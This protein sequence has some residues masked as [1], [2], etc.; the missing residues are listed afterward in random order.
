LDS[1]LDGPIGELLFAEGVTGPACLDAGFLDGVALQELVELSLF[2]PTFVVVVEL[3]APR[4]GVD[5]GGVV[6]TGPEKSVAVPV[7]GSGRPSLRQ[8]AIN[9]AE[10]LTCVLIATIW[11][12]NFS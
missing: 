5:D 1:K 6:P 8:A 7:V 2:A 12:M 4:A 9:A 11:L 10:S 3:D